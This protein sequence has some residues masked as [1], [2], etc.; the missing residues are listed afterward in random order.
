MF[1]LSTPYPLIKVLL[2][3]AYKW[4]YWNL[5]ILQLGGSEITTNIYTGYST[6]KI[7]IY[8]LLHLVVL[9]VRF[10]LGDKTW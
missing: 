2:F 8:I 1:V 9:S 3:L 6:T 10:Q 4:N 7:A 5:D